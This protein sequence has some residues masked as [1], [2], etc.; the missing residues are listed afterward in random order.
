MKLIHSPQL[1]TNHY[2]QSLSCMQPPSPN[3]QSL[4]YYTEKNSIHSICSFTEFSYL[5]E[6]DEK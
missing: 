1:T 4:F 5:L 6:S 3:I 2:Q